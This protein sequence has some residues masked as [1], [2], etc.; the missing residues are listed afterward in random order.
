VVGNS[1]RA[2][3]IHGRSHR[4]S[5]YN[6]V[7]WTLE[8][9]GVGGWRVAEIEA[10]Q[11]P[12]RLPDAQASAVNT[13]G[14]VAG[15]YLNRQII[16]DAAKWLTTGNLE[17]LPSP[18]FGAARARGIDNQGRIV[19]SVWDEATGSERAALWRLQ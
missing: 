16:Y 19:G 2:G 9:D 8:S 11:L 14:E 18:G 6:P 3:T 1:A 7:R 17:T 13:A 5:G 4:Q 12:G 15:Y 10:L